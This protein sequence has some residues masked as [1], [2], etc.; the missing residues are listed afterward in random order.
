[1]V[2]TAISGCSNFGVALGVLELGETL[3]LATVSPE[4]A[5]EC[6]FKKRGNVE[7]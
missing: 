7:L 2:Y 3:F 5:S 4:H 1:M 6:P